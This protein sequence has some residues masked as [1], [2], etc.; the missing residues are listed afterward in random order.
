MSIGKNKYKKIIAQIVLVLFLFE[1][2]NGLQVSP[3]PISKRDMKKE[4]GLEVKRDISAES[5]MMGDESELTTEMQHLS[6]RSL[7]GTINLATLNATQGVVIQ[8]VNAGDESGYSVSGAGDVNGDG[9][10]DVIIGAFNAN[11]E[12]GTSYVVYGSKTLGTTINLAALNAT[13]GVAIQGAAAGDEA[14]WSVSGAGDVNGDGIA[15]VIIG[16]P[17]TN[18][19]E[20]SS[21]VVYG[22][23]T[24]GTTINLAA[25]NATQGV[26]IQGAAAG[27]EAG[28]SVSGA[29]DVNGDGIADVI[30]GAPGTN[31]QAGSSY[32]VYGSNTLGTTINLA[33]L[34]ATQGVVIQGAAAG[35]E[36]G[37][38]VSGA[39]D[40]NGDGIADVIIGAP[41]TDSSYVVYGSK[42]LGTT[43]NLAAL[44]ATQGVVIQGTGGSDSG[45]SVSGAVDVNGDGI[46]DVIIGATNTNN[47]AGTSYV[48]Y[49]E[50][51][52]SASPS[53]SPSPSMSSASPSP[54]PS[55]SPSASPSPSPSAS[56][57]ASM[58]SASRYETLL[59]SASRSVKSLI[60]WIRGGGE[61]TEVTLATSNPYIKEMLSIQTNCRKLIKEADEKTADK[62][63]GY[64]LED[65]QEEMG[66]ALK[67]PQAIDKET[68]RHF[69]N[70]LGDVNRNFLS[71]P[72]LE[73]ATFFTG[74]NNRVEVS[75]FGINNENVLLQPTMIPMLGAGYVPLALGN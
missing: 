31:N 4:K 48:V 35:D 71:K 51:A 73:K 44:N 20:G 58:S 28:F 25:L 52:P 19:F 6:S 11:N 41:G 8:G 65:L 63:Y 55:P 40:V 70:L 64:S 37:Y 10:A 12:A 46:A 13:Q 9:I 75:S 17:D 69:R 39:G 67:R 5:I 66:K 23:K 26:V 14:G 49:G 60:S 18:N 43:I 45:N 61:E 62:W 50:P 42:T 54:S 24:L 68:V 33:A 3:G 74:I 56:A 29:G 2:C 57:S 22:S 36:S 30:I 32:V 16:A 7:P 47:N 15:D 72:M 1:N 59:S 34:N 53:A 38:S 27:D 21:Y